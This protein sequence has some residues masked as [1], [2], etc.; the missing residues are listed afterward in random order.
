MK[1][2]KTTHNAGYKVWTGRRIELIS[3]LDMWLAHCGDADA[4]A[5]IKATIERNEET[6][7]INSAST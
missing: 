2:V 3:T 5:R 1:E 7:R 4:K 6:L